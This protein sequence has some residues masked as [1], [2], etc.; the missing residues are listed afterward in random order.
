MAQAKYVNKK[1]LVQSEAMLAY[2]EAK[3]LAEIEQHRKELAAEQ[4]A[5]ALAESAKREAEL[6]AFG[7]KRIALYVEDNKYSAIAEQVQ[8]FINWAVCTVDAMEQYGISVTEEA[9]RSYTM[10]PA[11]LKAA[12]IEGEKKKYG[13]KGD[14]YYSEYL[15]QR[16]KKD[17]NELSAFEAR[18]SGRGEALNSDPKFSTWDEAE[19]VFNINEAAISEHCTRYAE[20]EEAFLFECLEDATAILNEVFGGT[21]PVHF[22]QIWTWN[23]GL[24]TLNK[25][26]N[27]RFWCGKQRSEDLF[28]G[29]E[30]A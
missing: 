22:N 20:G 18:P 30:E 26:I 24:L 10:E 13:K 23:N 5:E 3:K 11:K 15:E 2:W 19:K 16:V 29:S 27:L 8:N 14:P 7:G 1:K 25:E 17:L 12:I 4:E 6:K 21:A 9:V 28:E